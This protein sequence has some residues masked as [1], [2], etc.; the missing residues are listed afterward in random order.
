MPAVEVVQR[1]VAMVEAGRYVE[2][3]EQFYT[4]DASMQ[5][6]QNEPRRG[7]AVLAAHE[8]SVL[9]R[10][11]EVSTRPGT[12]LVVDGDRVVIRWRFELAYADGRRTALDEIAWQRWSGDLIAEECFYYDPAQHHIEVKP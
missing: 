1:F 4:E 7:R 3:I 12:Q 9:A 5:E 10:M 11:K 2:A 6:N 8:G